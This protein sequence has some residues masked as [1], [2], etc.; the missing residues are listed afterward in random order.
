MQRVA[1]MRGKASDADPNREAATSHVQAYLAHEKYAPR[2][3]LQ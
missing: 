1:T 3:T 2:R